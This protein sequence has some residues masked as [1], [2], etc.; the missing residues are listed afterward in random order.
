[1]FN[2]GAIL[3]NLKAVPVDY[4]YQ[5]L[6]DN[7][8]KEL[9]PSFAEDVRVVYTNVYQNQL[10]VIFTVNENQTA[11]LNNLENTLKDP[12]FTQEVFKAFEPIDKTYYFNN[13]LTLLQ[14]LEAR[15]EKV[16]SV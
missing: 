14:C 15:Q 16:M 8:Q 6:V 3:V 13:N 2:T 4:N 11:N 7:F 1:M 5:E 10:K 12:A 9:S